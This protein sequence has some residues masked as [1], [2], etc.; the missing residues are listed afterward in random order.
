M[1]PVR[2]RSQ[3]V[4]SFRMGKTDVV[5]R[6]HWLPFL[7]FPL[8]IQE[9]I[10]SYLQFGTI[11]K[12]R[13]VCRQFNLICSSLLNK[14]FCRLR[15]LVQQH[16]LNI[17]QQMPRR[18]SA[19]RK[20][21]LARRNDI[22]DTLHMQLTLLQM[23]FGKHIERKFCCFFPGEIL[24]EVHKIL[25]YVKITPNPCQAFKVTDELFDLTTMAMD[26]FKEHIETTLPEVTYFATDVLDYMPS[27][28]KNHF[29]NNQKLLNEDSS[30][31]SSDA[32]ILD[33]PTMKKQLM[34]LH[35]NTKRNNRQAALLKKKLRS[36]Q[37]HMTKQQKQ[38]IE[39]KI[40]LERYD[41]KLQDM[42]H[43]LNSVVRE[44]SH[45]K[46]ELQFWRSKSPA[47]QCICGKATPVKEL[48]E[49]LSDR[50]EIEE[51]KPISAQMD[52][53]ST[54]CS[55]SWMSLSSE[56]STSDAV[57]L[58]SSHFPLIEESVR[59]K[60]IDSGFEQME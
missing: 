26:Y 15:V 21:P 39:L 55:C 24:D 12:I 52:D 30:T 36:A 33:Y 60:D 37:Q 2:R 8:C 1:A 9:M 20:H 18:E 25:K 14:E 50:H 53:L 48:K 51:F 57:E 44:L 13:A 10:F 5:D 54:M 56:M 43:K 4:S 42:S 41:A 23:T 29:T 19:R 49:D 35:S 34:K 27:N 40:K 58:H 16:F 17:K 32:S 3:N 38:M 22:V 31:S 7:D 46:T 11:S 45:C 28:P 59:I 6:N 47:V